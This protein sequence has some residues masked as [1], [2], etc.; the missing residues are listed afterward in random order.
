MIELTTLGTCAVRRLGNGSAE[1]I[2]VPPKRL[3]LLSYLV[4]ARPR[5]FQRRDIL[6]AMF[7]PE[8]DQTHARNALSQALHAT[9]RALGEGLIVSRGR[10][11]TAPSDGAVVCDAFTFEQ[12]L[13]AGRLAEALELYRG[14]LLHGLHVTGA[15][16]FEHWLDGERTRLRRQAR[17][18]ASRL[19]DVGETEGNLV[20]AARW[21][22]RGLEIIPVDETLVRRLISVLH[23]AGD[24]TGAITAYERFTRVLE[25]EYET[26]ASAETR[27]LIDIVRAPG[28]TLPPSPPGGTV[29]AGTIRSIAVLPLHSLGADDM[30][31]YS[32]D[33]M[34]EALVMELGRIR[35]LRVISLQSVLQFKGSRQPL[36]DI[37]RLLGVEALVEGSVLEAG[38]RVRI[39]AQLVRADPE[40]HLWADAFE[41]DARDV[42]S[43]HRDVARAIGSAVAAALSTEEER[44]LRSA[45]PVN[46]A[47]YHA[48][49]QGWIRHATLLPG[50]MA[51]AIP[52]YMKAVSLDPSFAPPRAHLAQTHFVLLSMGE[53]RVEE[54]VAAMREAADLAVTLD[55]TLAVGYASQ[56]L[57]RMAMHDW[58]SAEERLRLAVTMAPSLAIAHGNLCAFLTGMARFDEGAQ[59]AERARRL[60]PL[61]P[62]AN[63]LGGWCLHYA[64]RAEESIRDHRRVLELFPEYP[65]AWIFIAKSHYQLGDRRATVEA[66]RRSLDLLP[67]NPMTLAY[68]THMLAG[69]GE[70]AMAQ[71]AM[72]RLEHQRT[73]RGT[74]AP[75]YD[76]IAL[77][78]LGRREEALARLDEIRSDA[79]TTGWLLKVD[80]LLDPL[81]DDRR[82]DA[83]LQR[84]GLADHP[85]GVP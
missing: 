81:R 70:R 76:A 10:E 38:G 82:F 66:C 47:A 35:S 20:A 64:R 29:P 4:L 78:G 23:R 11:E 53:L 71:G 50:E 5:G 30:R 56:G 57:A 28:Q 74:I 61:A 48:H 62:Y 31:A 83:V 17:D 72:D 22:E 2:D 34:T 7:W 18:A 42:I 15:D 19:A 37:A 12:H 36:R 84:V 43:V 49:L 80:P 21:L 67:E 46:P 25:S 60:D 45:Q 65:L 55:P 79:S 32:A 68:V 58:T 13:L 9:R 39:T 77:C 51:Q 73:V 44:Q 3:A 16:G 52:L 54:N 41:A 59:A 6:C 1:S 14:D 85:A 26:E 33:G 8:A 69:I 27:A 24:R 40:E 75:Y 63:W